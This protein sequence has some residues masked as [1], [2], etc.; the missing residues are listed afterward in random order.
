MLPHLFI[1]D[2]ERSPCRG[3][4]L[5]WAAATPLPAGKSK[6]KLSSVQVGFRRQA[7]L[8]C[9]WRVKQQVGW[10]CTG[11]YLTNTIALAAGHNGW[12]PGWAFVC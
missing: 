2:R 3:L 5:A 1:M 4:G 11:Y 7:G 9:R 6:E 12:G 10:W 8:D